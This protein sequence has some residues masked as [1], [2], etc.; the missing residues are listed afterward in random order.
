MKQIFLGLIIFLTATILLENCKKGNSKLNGDDKLTNTINSPV[1][2]SLNQ[3]RTPSDSELT[4]LNNFLKTDNWVQFAKDNPI[5]VNNIDLSKTDLVTM[6]SEGVHSN[7]ILVYLPIVSELNDSYIVVSTTETDYKNNKFDNFYI[8]FQK[9]IKITPYPYLENRKYSTGDLEIYGV[10]LSL[11]VNEFL[12]N[13]S[14][15]C[16]ST[17]GH[18]SRYLNQTTDFAGRV[19]PSGSCVAES[20]DNQVANCTGWCHILFECDATMIIHAAYAATAVLWCSTHNNNPWN[21]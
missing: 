9:N 18:P 6:Y 14:L 3:Q 5:L 17:W 12:E 8:L 4:T 2:P 13:D 11:H 19:V 1:S 7:L 20:Y 16:N 10:N 21:V 15:T